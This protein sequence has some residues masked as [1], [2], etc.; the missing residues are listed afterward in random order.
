MDKRKLKFVREYLSKI[1][2]ETIDK[3]YGH[4]IIDEEFAKNKPAS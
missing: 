3:Y 2:N 4:E 1:D